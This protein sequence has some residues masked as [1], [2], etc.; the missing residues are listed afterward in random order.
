MCCKNEFLVTLIDPCGDEGENHPINC[1]NL[2]MIRDILLGIE[3][4]FDLICQ[5]EPTD[6]EISRG[7]I[8]RYSNS[9]SYVSITPCVIHDIKDI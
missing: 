8:V 3:Q 9:V 6:E 4:D 7:T 2:Q 5:H 1:K